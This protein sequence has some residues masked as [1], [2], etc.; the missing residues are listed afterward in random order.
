MK[1]RR[2][3]ATVSGHVLRRPLGSGRGRWRSA[4]GNLPT[5]TSQETYPVH[6]H[7]FSAWKRRTS[8]A[9][10]HVIFPSPPS[11]RSQKDRD[12]AHASVVARRLAMRSVAGCAR[13]RAPASPRRSPRTAPTSSAATSDELTVI[14]LDTLEI[15]GRV[16][17]AASPTTWPSSTPTSP[18]STSIRRRPTRRSSSTRET[19]EVDEAHPA[20]RAPDAHLA[21]PR[22]QRARRR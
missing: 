14:D 22:R 13:N 3:P 5:P 6:R 7:F 4:A 10:W 9:T 19:L 8:P 11:D 21:E 18:R 17:T 1:V 12:E 20:R 15:V 16:Q 2:G